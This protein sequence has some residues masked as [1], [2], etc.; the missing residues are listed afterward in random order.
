MT[1]ITRIR[2]VAEDNYSSRE[3]D[4]RS[5]F[6]DDFSN[7]KIAQNAP[8]VKNQ[9]MQNGKNY[10]KGAYLPPE[11]M[12]GDALLDPSGERGNEGTRDGKPVPYDEAFDAAAV[13]EA[14]GQCPSLQRPVADLLD[15]FLTPH[16]SFSCHTDIPA[17]IQ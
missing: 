13:D 14:D 3:D 17:L 9:S 4:S 12:T 1:D 2:K 16:S 15:S 6:P 11:R 10:S 7:T 8:G 5:V